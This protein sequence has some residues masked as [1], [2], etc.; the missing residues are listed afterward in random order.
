MSCNT[1]NIEIFWFLVF[2]LTLTHQLLRRYKILSHYLFTYFF[3]FVYFLSNSSWYL[4][5][6]LLRS[7]TYGL[8]HF[9]IFYRLFPSLTVVSLTHITIPF[10]F[11][12]FSTV[13]RSPNTPT[14]PLKN[15]PPRASTASTSPSLVLIT[16]SSNYLARWRWRKV[17]LWSITV[18]SISMSLIVTSTF[19][20][21]FIFLGFTKFCFVLFGLWN[22]SKCLNKCLN[23]MPLI[24]SFR[25]SVIEF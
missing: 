22:P 6:C 20:Y 21:L 14:P 10:L 5:Q 17:K 15:S 23:R 24:V 8:F 4:L 12:L 13:K 9:S 2:L 18:P 7:Q 25:N 11:L 1:Y 3:L 16:R 19:I